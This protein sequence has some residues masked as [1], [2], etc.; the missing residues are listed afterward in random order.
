MDVFD[1]MDENN[2]KRYNQNKRGDS[3]MDAARQVMLEQSHSEEPDWISTGDA[4][5]ILGVGSINTVKRWVAAK[6]LVSRRLGGER[7]WMQISKQSIQDLLNSKDPEILQVQAQQQDWKKVNEAM[8]GELDRE[9]MEDL[10]WREQTK[11]G[12]LPWE[13]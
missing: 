7:G 12:R 3:D 4:A 10:S 11:S 2:R 8:G 9:M 6:K 5:K 1:D 13:K